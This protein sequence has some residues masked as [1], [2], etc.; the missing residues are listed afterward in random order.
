MSLRENG[1]GQNAGAS[2]MQLFDNRQSIKLADIEVE[3]NYIKKSRMVGNKQQLCCEMSIDAKVAVH[4][5]PSHQFQPRQEFIGKLCSRDAMQLKDVDV[6][7]AEVLY[8]FA[9]CGFDVV[10]AIV[11]VVPLGSRHPKQ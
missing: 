7:A 5:A 8:R 1:P 6:I 11:C 10:G 9:T 4:A 3:Q 2:C